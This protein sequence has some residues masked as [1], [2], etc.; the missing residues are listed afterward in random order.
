MSIHVNTS[1]IKT[2]FCSF[3]DKDLS[4]LASEG[5]P[6]ALEVWHDFGS[7]ISEALA[8]FVLSFR[9]QLLLFG[10]QISKAMEYFG[11]P[12]RTAFPDL[13][14]SSVPDTTESMF[15]GLYTAMTA[16]ERV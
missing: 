6:A 10:G 4:R 1:Y 7:L 12:V 8:P 11:D 14:M 3:F 16:D 15:R 13:L 5:D 9:P 2:E